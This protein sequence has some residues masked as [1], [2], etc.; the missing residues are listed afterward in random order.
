MSEQSLSDREGKEMRALMRFWRERKGQ[1]LVEYALIIALVSIAVIAA[2]TLLG[3]G[4][5]TAFNTI[6]ASL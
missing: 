6:V 3:G 4:I 5:T 1:G 2:L